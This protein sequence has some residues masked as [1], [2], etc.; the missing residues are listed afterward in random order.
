MNIDDLLF[1]QDDSYEYKE[2]EVR[3][4][5]R[6]L[7]IRIGMLFLNEE[8]LYK[9][10]TNLKKILIAYNKRFLSQEEKEKLE[11]EIYSEIEFNL[12]YFPGYDNV[13][14]KSI[15]IIKDTL[16]YDVADRKRYRII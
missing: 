2:L 10:E 5:L 3:A 7:A 14:D 6:G 4:L 9:Y 16:I 12:S 8:Q 15:N 11:E 1:I 13:S